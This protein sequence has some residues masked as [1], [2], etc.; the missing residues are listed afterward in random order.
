M[1]THLYTHQR[2]FV[3]SFVFRGN[4]QNCWYIT[5]KNQHGKLFHFLCSLSKIF[6]KTSVARL[7][8]PLQLS[9]RV[10]SSRGSQ[11]N[12][13]LQPNANEEPW[14]GAKI[15]NVDVATV[16]CHV[17]L[18][19]KKYQSVWEQGP[20]IFRCK[21]CTEGIGR[22]GVWGSLFRLSGSVS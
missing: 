14:Y 21:F 5:A 7:K 1:K 9:N 10:N 6:A 11:K 12:E 19:K 18:A 8:I 17:R 22:E 4:S 15:R 16:F 20:V 3:S 2:L 13:D